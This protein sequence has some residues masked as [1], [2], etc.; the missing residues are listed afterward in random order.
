MRPQEI[1]LDREAE[2][3]PPWLYQKTVVVSGGYGAKSSPVVLFFVFNVF[4]LK[5]VN[6]NEAVRMCVS[7]CVYPSQSI[8]QKFEVIIIPGFVQSP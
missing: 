1:D 5:K 7:V 6:T 2:T 3:R 4:T 8:P